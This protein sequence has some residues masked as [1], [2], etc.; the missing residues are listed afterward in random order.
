MNQKGVHAFG[1]KDF[2]GSKLLS[3]GISLT[4]F[5]GGASSSM[6]V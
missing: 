6:R 4:E 5:I 3:F 2:L 1:R